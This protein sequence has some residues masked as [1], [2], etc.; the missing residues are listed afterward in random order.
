LD[1]KEE[2]TL[3]VGVAVSFLAEMMMRRGKYSF[4]V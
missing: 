2:T 1:T 4:I 3:T